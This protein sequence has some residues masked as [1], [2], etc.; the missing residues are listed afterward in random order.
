MGA[1]NGRLCCV[2]PP[3]LQRISFTGD[4]DNDDKITRPIATIIIIIIKAE[5]QVSRPGI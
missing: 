2:W 1:W 4:N 5:E 3:L